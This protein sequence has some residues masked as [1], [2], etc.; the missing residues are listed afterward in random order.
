[1]A[2]TE[3]VWALHDAMSK[4]LRGTVLLGAFAALSA[5][6]VCGLRVSDIDFMQGVV[7]PEV[8][9]PAAPLKTK[10]GKTPEPIP[11]QMTLALSACVVAVEAETSL[12]M[13]ESRDQLSPRTMERAF[14]AARD[15]SI[16]AE[17]EVKL[18]ARAW[19]NESFRF[20]D[21]RRYF[22]IY[23]IA[24]GVDAKTVQKRMR[25]AS[26]KTTLDVYGHLSRTATTP[27]VTLQRCLRGR[28]GNRPR[29]GGCGPSEHAP[30]ERQERPAI[31][32]SGRST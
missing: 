11:A 2:S 8:Q 19:L 17:I 13:N 16:A 9:Y 4:H 18:P 21:L 29:L 3:Q 23:L 24:L 30:Y 20:H 6:E 22:A 26:A 32:I 1:M 15:A 5:A 7:S 12:F 27:R 25:H 31:S 10:G 28:P 14:L